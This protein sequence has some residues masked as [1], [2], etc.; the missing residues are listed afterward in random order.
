V[1]LEQLIAAVGGAR[2]LRL[3]MLDAYRDNPFAPTNEADDGDATG[4]HGDG[5][6]CPFATALARQGAACRGAKIVRHRPRRRLTPTK[7]V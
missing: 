5:V 7:H 6:D 1:A 3:V 2:K 4:R